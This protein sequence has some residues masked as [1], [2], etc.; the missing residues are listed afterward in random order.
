MLLQKHWEW[1]LSAVLVVNLLDLNIAVRQVVV[2]NEVLVS[3][4]EASVLPQDIEAQNFSVIV[5]EAFKSLVWSSSL[6]L[7]FNVVFQFSLI[8]WSL[9]IVYHSSSLGEQVFWI[10]LWGIEVVALHGIESSSEVIG[11]HNSE[12]SL[13][14]IEVESNI[15]VFPGV[16]FG[17]VFWVWQFVS[18]QETSLWDS[19]V[20]D[21]WFIDLNGVVVE[22]V[23]DF[24]L[25]SSEI[26]VW[27]FNNWLNEKGFEYKLLYKVQN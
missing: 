20:L 26:L 3:T 9:L 24:A 6:Q 4:I 21:F 8:G 19:G 11:V 7:N 17:F 22:E 25:S 23:V 1:I 18:L 13:I 14:N 5:Q 2:K 27:I 15:D 10:A 12:Y 16:E